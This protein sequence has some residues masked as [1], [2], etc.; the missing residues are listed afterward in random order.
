MKKRM[1]GGHEMGH[2]M[3]HET[4][5]SFPESL[6]TRGGSV[7][8]LSAKGIL[9]QGRKLSAKGS[10]KQVRK[11][12]H[13]TSAGERVKPDGQMAWAIYLSFQF[14]SAPDARAGDSIRSFVSSSASDELSARL[15]PCVKL[16]WYRL[17]TSQMTE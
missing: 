10:V 3:R 15:E 4:H 2:E 16:S 5:M 12:V 13:E 9:V 14:E 17:I 11:E 8:S 7:T 6:R 1:K